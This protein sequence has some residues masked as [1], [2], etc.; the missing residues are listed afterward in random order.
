MLPSSSDLRSGLGDNS[1]QANHN[2]RSVKSKSPEHSVTAFNS[3]Q[4]IML[5]GSQLQIVP[6]EPTYLAVAPKPSRT[7]PSAALKTAL[8]FAGCAE[9]TIWATAVTLRH[10]IIS[11]IAATPLVI[12]PDSTFDVKRGRLQRA[13]V[14]LVGGAASLGDSR[15]SRPTGCCRSAS[16]HCSS[17]LRTSSAYNDL[18]P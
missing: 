4:C 17:R 5:D 18:Y 11:V 8:S 6:L 14:P 12:L 13:V 2:S 1:T 7:T 9:S 10:C 15:T 16:E 3:R